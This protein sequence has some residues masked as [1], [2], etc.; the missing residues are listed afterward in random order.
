MSKEHDT[1]RAL[2]K[3]IAEAEKVKTEPD[4]EDKESEEDP[5]EESTGDERLAMKAYADFVRPIVS[6][7]NEIRILQWR[8]KEWVDVKGISRMF[9]LA[10]IKDRIV[11][12]NT[13]DAKH[14]LSLIKRKGKNFEY[15]LAREYSPCLYVRCK[16]GTEEVTM[17]ELKNFHKVMKTDGKAD[18]VFFFDDSE[19]RV[20][21]D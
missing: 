3:Q 18:E 10:F 6:G 1:I 5:L 4:T 11:K 7:A 16:P 17:A 2:R 19:L 14:V 21:W 15:Q 9:T 12:Q 8:A 13:F 20:W